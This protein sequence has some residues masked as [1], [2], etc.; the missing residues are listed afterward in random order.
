MLTVRTLSDLTA[1]VLR[2]HPDGLPLPHLVKAVKAA[3][4]AGATGGLASA[5]GGASGLRCPGSAVRG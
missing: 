4:G 3:G 2:D 1:D 5:G